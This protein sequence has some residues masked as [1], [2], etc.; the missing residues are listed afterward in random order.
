MAAPSNAGVLEGAHAQSCSTV[1]PD[2]LE[3]EPIS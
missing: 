2:L 1:I 3:A